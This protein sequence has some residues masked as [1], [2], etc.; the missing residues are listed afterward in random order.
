[1]VD[2]F[3]EAITLLNTQPDI[4]LVCIKAYEKPV[5]SLQLLNFLTI[6]PSGSLTIDPF[7]GCDPKN[8][9]QI[10]GFNSEIADS[11]SSSFAKLREALCQA[12]A[13]ERPQTVI[14]CEDG[15]SNLRHIDFAVP[16]RKRDVLI[17]EEN[18]SSLIKGDIQVSMALHGSGTVFFKNSIGGLERRCARNIDPHSVRY[19]LKKES[20]RENLFQTWGSST[21]Q[22]YR[23]DTG[24]INIF[25]KNN[26][27]E[28]YE[29]CEHR[30]PLRLF[31]GR[32]NPN[33]RT[34]VLITVPAYP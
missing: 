18:A 17:S 2:C 27:P 12:F 29:P 30:S 34:V 26:W 8:F 5:S 4:S 13:L 6:L 23:A 15:N 25:R 7:G 3:R 16:D 11:L 24:D 14:R 10:N 20:G 22:G 9:G 32:G 33:K 21:Q 28:G 1:L 31:P 19:Y